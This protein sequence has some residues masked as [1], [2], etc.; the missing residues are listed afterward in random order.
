MS[1]ALI[2]NLLNLIGLQIQFRC[3]GRNA[4][5]YF[6]QLIARTTHHGAGACARRR[7]VA[8]AQASLVVVAAA[9]ELVVR[10]ILDLHVTY[11]CRG[12]ATCCAA[13]Q[14]LFAQPFGKPG[15]MTIAIEWIRCEIPAKRPRTDIHKCVPKD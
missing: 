14:R 13:V 5:W 1:D 15:Q 6:L 11:L 4:T 12:S 2:V 7:T 3:L 10:Q 8:I 9:F